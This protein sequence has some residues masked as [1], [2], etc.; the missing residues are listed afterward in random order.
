MRLLSSS[1]VSGVVLE[2]KIG[3]AHAYYPRYYIGCYYRCMPKCR[4]AL[5]LPVTLQQGGSLPVS[6]RECCFLLGGFRLVRFSKILVM[7]VGT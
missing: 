4:I 1:R 2:D 5:I 6:K 3:V 7:R